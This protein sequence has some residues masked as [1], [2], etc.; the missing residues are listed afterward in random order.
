MF[1]DARQTLRS[2]AKRPL[3]SVLAVIIF[4]LAISVNTTVFSVFNGFFLRPLPFPEDDRLV[5]ISMSLPK[6]GVADGGTS[7]P[8]YLDW[9]A[10]AAALEHAA[11]YSPESRTLRGSELPEQIDITR[12]SPSFLSV[13][14][15]APTLGRGFTEDEAAPGNESVILL[16]HRLWTTRFGSRGDIVGREL[17]LD[18]DLFRVVGV[19]PEGFAFP[20]R[21]VDAWVPFAYTSRDAAIDQ[22]FNGVHQG[23]GRLRRDATLDSL[24]TQLDF[25]ARASLQRL[26][27]LAPFAEASGYTVR[28]REFRDYGVGDLEQRLL[29]LQVLV[30]AVLLIACANVANLQLSRMVGR[31]KELA[32]RAALG[33][34]M[35]RLAKLVVIESV[36]LALVGAI[37]GLMFAY[38]GIE[39]VR[40]LG[41][42]RASK[43]FDVQLDA[44]VLVVTLSAA[45]VAA[46]LSAV[47]PLLMLR[48]DD[49]ARVV[50]ESGRATLCSPATQRWRNALVVMQIS[51]GIALSVGAGL[52]TKAFYQLQERG[53]GFEAVGIW[54]AA[55]VLPLTRY[56]ESADQAR[57]I[58]EV[59][60]ELRSLPGVNG[61]GF[62]TALPFSGQNTGATVVVDDYAPVSNG[63]PPASQLR[64]IDDGYFEAL[65]IPVVMGRNFAAT[66]AER[67][68]IV[69]ESFAKTHW[70]NGNALGKRVRSGDDSPDDWYTIIGV[71]PHVKHE[72]FSSDQFEHTLYWHY[73]Q[74]PQA[75]GS[76]VLRSS[77]PAD[78]FTTPARAAVARLDPGL[79]LYDVVPMD[80]RVLRALGPERASMVL[81]LAFAI[82]AVALAV[83]GVY[84]VLAWS[85]AQRVGEI[86]VRMA[87]G[88]Q[89]ARV[90][91][92]ILG[93]GA[94][95]IALGL[96]LGTVGA[97][98]LGRLLAAR[99]P[100]VD[101]V[102]PL[103][104]AVAAFS[105]AAAAFAASWLPAHRAGQIDP[106]QA[107][108]DE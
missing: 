83:I 35:R 70:P 46:L 39:L 6:I 27:Q 55:F 90:V 45:L 64:S 88:A 98:A 13:L 94:R 42:E 63:P 61:A 11:I 82:I 71:V 69:D 97:I 72:S 44:T 96:L 41:L 105:L 19:M 4:A 76:L 51:A 28:A 24:N 31:R 73:A 3:S 91:W 9:R 57:F 26:P 81:T 104:I 34:G 2:L 16:S 60:D 99:I 87:L 20:D 66:E 58:A 93:Q 84:G 86:G 40:V 65:G 48:R 108:R 12:A 7:I 23:I 22:S 52:L 17:Q 79:A 47:L 5:V 92:M 62:T 38:G 50:L 36:G 25:L 29:A 101:A 68:A 59:L 77:L 56:G 21:D 89:R 80:E 43:G 75:A 54:S 103:V 85:T 18:D 106:M 32:V 8:G 107:L 95:M 1:Q 67:V 37:A 53:P 10:N 15:I 74:R 33:A 78:S 102:D 30:L 14:G 49:F 100:E